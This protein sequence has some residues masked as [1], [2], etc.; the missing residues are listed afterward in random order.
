[1][2]NIEYH[3]SFQ[4]IFSQIQKYEIINYIFE[5]NNTSELTKDY[6]KLLFNEVLK[7]LNDKTGDLEQTEFLKN[8]ILKFKDNKQDLQSFVNII[9]TVIKEYKILKKI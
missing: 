2:L 3:E 8:I 7:A 5:G 9:G 4:Y 6:Y 1:M